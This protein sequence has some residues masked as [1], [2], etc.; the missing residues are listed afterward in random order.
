MVKYLG[1]KRV[2]LPRIVETVLGAWR[3]HAG[4]RALC[5]DQRILDIRPESIHQRTALICG[6]PSEMDFYEKCLAAAAES[7]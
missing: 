5:G 2:L 1:S 6:G 3:E 7:G 4:G